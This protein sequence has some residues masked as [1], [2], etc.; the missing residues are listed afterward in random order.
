METKRC[1]RC[2]KILPVS[3]FNKHTQTKCGL[4][5]Y[6]KKCDK[7]YQKS[8]RELSPTQA[9]YYH[10]GRRYKITKE[11]YHGLLEAQGG[12]CA[13]CKGENRQSDKRTGKNRSLHVDHNHKTGSI[14]GLLCHKCNLAL[15]FLNEDVKKIKSMIKYLEKYS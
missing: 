15:G 14:R 8:R 7:E 12:S 5:S 13:I 11:N 2:K 10:L 3:Y 4:H 6:C 9:K 1:G